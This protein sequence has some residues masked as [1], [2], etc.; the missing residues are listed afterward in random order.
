VD[1]VIANKQL[2]YQLI[3]NNNKLIILC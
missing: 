1:S 2:I 3:K